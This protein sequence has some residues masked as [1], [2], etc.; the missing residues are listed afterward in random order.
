MG[1]E[2]RK[3]AFRHEYK[4]L[5][6]EQQLELVATQIASIMQLDK[7]VN[8]EGKDAGT[9]NIRSLYFDDYDNTCYFENE[10]GT[11]PREKFRIRI[12]NHQ[13]K[14]IFLELKK[15]ARGKCIK[16]SCTL[17]R[18]LC[19]EIIAGKKPAICNCNHP[20]LNKFLIQM[21]TRQLHPVVIVEYDRTP[22]VYNL[23]NVRV[24][25]DRNIRSSKSEELFNPQL[26]LRPILPVGQHVLEVKWDEYLPD[27]IYKTVMIDQLQWTSFSKFYLCRKYSV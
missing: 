19:D 17:S 12:Y 27:Y 11:D 6:S 8:Q 1:N 2:Y 3:D 20:L 5:V 25:F 7:H 21:E 13:D 14:N 22:Y 18:E 10:N 9:Y 26:P 16:N 23:G 24:T 15:K 4:Y